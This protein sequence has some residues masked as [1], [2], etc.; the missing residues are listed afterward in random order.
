MHFR[1]LRTQLIF[2]VT[3][4]VATVVFVQL[5]IRAFVISPQIKDLTNE[6]V[7]FELLRLTSEVNQEF[8]AL[9]NL[10]Y[11]NAVWDETYKAVSSRDI[12]WFKETYFIPSSYSTLGITGWYFFDAQSQ[13]VAGEYKRTVVNSKV[14]I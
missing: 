11:D 12:G 1:T 6:H 3:L 9:E 7:K 4:V 10:S 5:C 14:S 2:A 8:R 13:L